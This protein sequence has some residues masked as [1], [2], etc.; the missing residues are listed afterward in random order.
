MKSLFAG[1]CTLA[2]FSLIPL[3]QSIQ[4]QAAAVTEDSVRP[5]SYNVAEESTLK[6]TVSSVLTKSTPGMITGSHLLVNTASG[7][8]D[9]SLGTFGLRGKG[10][11]PVRAGDPVEITGILKT[12]KNKPV[13]LARTVKADNQIY[14][15]RNEHGFPVAP[16]AR[17][18]AS[19]KIAQKGEA[20]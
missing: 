6:G 20:L 12:I 19:R 16:R 5:F 3:Q 14:T 15:V 18:R 4:A 17:E 8:V 11:I 7:S 13:F 9:A 10:A 1:L 2:L